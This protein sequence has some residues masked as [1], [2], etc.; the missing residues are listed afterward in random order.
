MHLHASLPRPKR[1]ISWNYKTDS[2][3]WT[4]V[5]PVIDDSKQNTLPL[6]HF[7]IIM[8]K[9]HVLKGSRNNPQTLFLR[10][11][12]K[13]LRNSRQY[14]ARCEAVHLQTCN[15]LKF[16]LPFQKW[17]IAKHTA[18]HRRFSLYAREWCLRASKSV[19]KSKTAILRFW[20]FCP[21]SYI[22]NS[23]YIIFKVIYPTLGI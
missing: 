5:T 16:S 8:V 14:H 21:K 12:P 9:C 2:W 19:E 11:S 23:G 18:F 3:C 17:L 1:G 6:V 22:P 7:H 10:T 13:C 15:S 20:Y 4:T